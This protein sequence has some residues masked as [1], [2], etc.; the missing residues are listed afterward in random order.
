[1]IITYDFLTHI[2]L[3]SDMNDDAY[4]TAFDLYLFLTGKGDGYFIFFVCDTL[5]F[6][7]KT[8]R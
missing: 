8:I 6:L 4:C 3:A 2:K 7:S 5:H 1:M